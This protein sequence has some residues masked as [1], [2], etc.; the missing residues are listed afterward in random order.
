[1]SD[2]DRPQTPPPE[3]PA[4]QP[5]GEKYPKLAK[6]L[7]KEGREQKRDKPVTGKPPGLDDRDLGYGFGKKADLFDAEL[8]RDLETDVQAAMAGI[9]DAEMKE[10]FGEQRRS[11]EQQPA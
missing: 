11:K 6:L 2:S 8:E 1:M 10:L 7:R 4:E 3:Q 9:S 5:P